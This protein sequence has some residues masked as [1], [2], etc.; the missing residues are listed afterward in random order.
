MK[1][2]FF[3]VFEFGEIQCLLKNNAQNLAIL[4]VLLF[5]TTISTIAQ[6]NPKPD[7]NDNISLYKKLTGANLTYKQIG[8]SEI[9][10]SRS[11]GDNFNCSK[12]NGAA[13]SAN[14]SL[15]ADAVI[16]AV[17]VQWFALVDHGTS[18]SNPLRFY[19][20]LSTTIP[21]KFP[22][23][24]TQVITKNKGYVETVR[25]ANEDL[26]YEGYIADITAN[27]LAQ[28]NPAGTYTADVILTNDYANLREACA[29]TQENA[30]AWQMLVVYK[31]PTD[32]PGI[33]QIYVYD[34][35]RGFVNQSINVPVTGYKVFS[36]DVAGSIS[37]ASLQGDA[38][39]SGESIRLSD[40]SFGNFPSDFA[41]SGGYSNPAPG[42]GGGN[43][44]AYGAWD[45]DVVN[46][47]FTPNTTNLNLIAGSTGDVVLLDLIVLEI[48][49]GA[50]VVSKKTKTTTVNIGDNGTYE[51]TLKNSSKVDLK[52]V[53]TEDILPIGFTYAST[54][55]IT[56]NKATQT[57]TTAPTIGDTTLNWGTFDI[58]GEG[59]VVITFDVKVPLDE[60]TG[61]YQN[62]AT[63][64]VL[65]PNDTV[66]TNYYSG[67]SNDDDINVVDPCDPI[68]SGNIDTD[69]D[70]ISDICDLDDDN[71]GILD[72]DENICGNT[73]TPL[74]IEDFGVTSSGS[75]SPSTSIPLF[76]G[77][78]TDYTY[79]QLKSPRTNSLQ[80]DFYA[81]FNN[82][83][84]SASWANSNWQ[85]I[86][87]HT[88]GSLT[89]TKD[90]MLMINA[91]NTL[92]IIYQ[93]TITGIQAGALL[94]VSFWVLNLDVDNAINNV[95]QRVL[96]NIQ[97]ELW[98]NGALL[99]SPVNTGNI[100]REK[101]GSSTAWKYY[102]TVAPL[103]TLN[104]SNITVII[105]NNVKATFGN[106]I[107]IDDILVRQLCNT[108]SDGD[109]IPNSLD[110][111]SDNDGIPDV[112][113]A[114]GID[115]NN[116][117]MADGIVGKTPSTKGIPATANT[118]NTPTSSD[119]DS[120]P[121]Y[122][123][124]D[125][126]NDG[127]PDNIEAQPSGSYKKPSGIGVNM[128][129][130]NNNGLDDN[131]ELNGIGF[132]PENTDGDLI[133]DYLDSDSDNDGIKDINENGD[134]DNA[135][136]DINADKDGDGLN[137]VFDD[138]L[139]NP[140]I[141]FT[142]N[143][144][145][146]P[147]NK[148]IDTNSLEASFGDEDKNFNPGS[149]DL[150]Y[151]DFRD[152]D[153]DGIADFYD[154]DDDNDGIPDT[155]ENNGNF[156]DG[157]EDNDGIPNYRDNVDN[158][159][160]DGSTTNYT[161]SNNDNIPDVYD[162]DG[163]GIAN[164]L[165]LDS[166]NDGIPDIVEA[167]GEDTD[168]NGKVDDIRK[169]GTLKNDT[170][171]DG[172]DDRYDS[173]NGGQNIANLDTD[174]DGIPNSQDLDSDNDGITDI[175]EAGGLDADRNGKV[176]GGTDID[177]DGYNDLVDGD[178][179]QDGISENTANAL[180]ITGKDTNNNGKPN[181]YPNKD[182][183]N[184][185][186]LNYLDIDADNDGI[187]D[188]I[189]AQT[190]ILYI[191]PSNPS[192][193]ITDINKNG[194]D[195]NYEVGGIGFVPENTDNTDKPDYLDTDSD[196]DGLPDIYEN[197]DTDNTIL[198]INADADNDGLN[199]V[200][201]D[202]FNPTNT[203]ITVNDG[204][205]PNNEVIN[206]TTLE[207]SFGDTDSDF[208]PGIGDLD[209]RDVLE[210]AKVMITQV[211]QFGNEKWIEITNVGATNIPAN[212][213]NIQLYKNK[214][215]DQIG[216]NPDVS[217]TVNTILISGRSILFKNSANT[218]TNT[219]GNATIVTNSKIDLLTNLDD[220]VNDIITLSSASGVYS[221]EHKYDVLSNIKNKTSSVRIDETLTPNKTYTE[222]EWVVF[223]ND[224]DAPSS[225]DYLD[226]YRLL[227]DGS[228][229]RHP[230]D[231]L[232]SEV[233][234]SN[235]NANT[236]LG[237]HRI[238]ITTKIGTG[239][240]NGFP[241]RSRFVVI[242][243]N[244]DHTGTRLSARKLKVNASKKLAI[245]DNYLVV[246]NNIVLDG[247][248]RLVG[249]SQLIQTHTKASL[250]SGSGKLFVDQN[251]TVPS[252][253]RYNYMS[254][255]VNTIG[256]KTY[257]LESV[258]KD[259]TIP[260][261]ATSNIGI[262]AKDINFVA[263]YDG[264]VTNP[265]S[266]AEYWVNTYSPNSNGRSNWLQKY[267]SGTVQ[268]GEGF[269][270]K[271]P[272]KA[273]NY[274]F[275][276][277][278]ND[279]AFNTNSNIGAGES[280]LVGN[281]F[282]SSISVKKFIEDNINSTSATLY[283][284]QHVGESLAEGTA[285]HN[286][287]GYIGGYATRNISMGVTANDPKFNAPVN[288]TLEAEDASERNGIQLPLGGILNSV[289]SLNSTNY[290]KFSN[291]SRGVDSLRII[292]SS[293]LDRNL[294]I[295]INNVERGVFNF[296]K[297]FGSYTEKR[298]ALCIEAG[299]NITITSNNTLLS[300]ILIDKIV[301][302]DE[303]G[304]IACAPNTGGSEY[305]DDY[306]K[307]E[308]YIAIGQGFFIQGDATNG[309]PIV[310]NNSQ[311]EYKVEGTG[312]SVFLKSETNKSKRKSEFE[313]P[314]LKLGMNYSNNQNSNLHRQI[315]IS[316]HQANSFAFEKGYDSEMYDINAT[317]FYWKFPNND[318]SY[319]I[320][321]VQGISNNLEVP[322]EITVANNSVIT[323][324][325]DEIKYI[326]RDVFIKDKLTGKTQKINNASATYQ[327]EKGIYT[328]RFVLTFSAS[329]TAL[330]LEDNTL[331]EYTNIY[332]DNNN[333]RIVISKKQGININNVEL[334][335]ILGK[336]VS[337]WNIKEQKDNYSLDIK[338][339][340]TAGIYIV[341][342]NTNKGKINKK[343][344]I[345]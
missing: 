256:K 91:G 192:G 141:G 165:D 220:S 76:G 314:I 143:D 206:T 41:N 172:L 195:D 300:P 116:D 339:Q 147:N 122:L 61:V 109:G 320:A 92:D 164:H 259:G 327:L 118:G 319:V 258:L 191:P 304:K 282:P 278:P 201:D 307:P 59:S 249:T 222:N 214:T 17:Y 43:N 157:D 231:P 329:D 190:S 15:P 239:W 30:R 50:L 18:T 281:P 97:I 200:F 2:T 16:Q 242:N 25:F 75:V 202:N 20:P 321:G 128:L 88:N 23:G 291:I 132:I 173:N 244:Y 13:T 280:Y 28:P 66:I 342:L 117:G 187:P 273:Q 218:I 86:G 236:I 103:T 328:D 246:T 160:G 308:P 257:S 35:L 4:L 270:F 151:R 57:S 268:K 26:K 56:L 77:A 229:E 162:N 131:Y 276:G 224:I 285:G 107:A 301:L 266:I 105:R 272:G 316:F 193:A 230:H 11:S 85:K 338:K 137:D 79:L 310:F 288:F 63:A 226:P 134:K 67:D 152:A 344:I 336:N 293:L 112:I 154:L 153:K 136:I 10:Y 38:A 243:N 205:N 47:N 317:D 58:K 233:I 62:G 65:S 9:K 114:G 232:I 325:V 324:N 21:I 70:G 323:I 189:E 48:P 78:S 129:D 125:A 305:E 139:D 115:K 93:K 45:I 64:K 113:E 120:I 68:S 110:L 14:L 284:W 252:L 275:L 181:S 290:I 334:F 121:D 217:Y 213:I 53:T 34:G 55:S 27:V 150:D 161:D 208:N 42:T 87:D 247:E 96:P 255:P 311:R 24:S 1:K 60:P 39:I 126:D 140:N 340:I 168:G 171:N 287:A 108:D 295:K 8:N 119:A 130:A 37:I 167:G 156:A 83:S 138:N 212:N 54:A 298:I 155:T 178:V 306:L 194:V 303:D 101:S 182:A 144:G 309:G 127:I 19:A 73:G 148:V 46:S 100:V 124:I 179:G 227:A 49:T 251:S 163:D 177:N 289:I 203:R 238:N 253:Y 260:T 82:I 283:F 269:I 297:T 274:T 332:T 215:G 292:Y 294:K 216:V 322:L 104:S 174:N 277:T 29:L 146:S 207:S 335:D 279:G 99:G 219:K 286:F 241:D 5:T 51:I 175:I 263:G 12:N 296:P 237:L 265:I 331:A 170:D 176:D 271:G 337:I 333:H 183:D 184:D 180:I 145:L 80:D 330:G 326:H 264:N 111:D 36:G 197:G 345:E 40:N 228:P 98:Q 240:S 245:T 22:D 149:G 313:L 261:H 302:K 186:K 7:E 223:V 135:I 343:V 94:D 90:R 210:D 312:T 250:V 44:G 84:E 318:F 204:L 133:P 81:V 169:D 158:G 74:L 31:S 33:N 123:D 185:G 102:G 341:R 159:S 221:W 198:D 235:E 106:D 3:Q 95:P 32:E 72:V 196:N 188:N 211:Y 262:I 248:I 199:D 69:K 234:N 89:P 225:P 254:S 142:V 52:G 315:G 6:Q 71:D 267:K 166:D 299:S 209:Y